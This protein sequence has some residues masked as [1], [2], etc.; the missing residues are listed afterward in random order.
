MVEPGDDFEELGEDEPSGPLLPPDDRLWRHPSELFATGDRPF[1]NQVLA[2]RRQWLA[3]TP[4]RAGAGA[5]GLVGALL[6]AGVVL[7]GVHLTS[8]LTP[9]HHARPTS[10][11]AGLYAAPTE[12]TLP[13][14]SAVGLAGFFDSLNAAIVKVRAVVGARQVM[15]DGVVI[16]QSGDILVAARS[17][18]GALSV[19]V[20]LSDGEELPASLLGSDS[21]TGIAVLKIPEGNLSWLAFSTNH[22]TPVN[23]FLVTAWKRQRLAMQLVSLVKRPARTGLD[24]GPSLLEL[25][26]GSLRLGR[27]PNGAALFDSSGQVIGFVTGHAGHRAVAV[28]GWLAIRVA[29]QLVSNGH[30]SHGWLGIVGETTELSRKVL[31]AVESS[32]PGVLGS[33]HGL[34]RHGVR[35]LSV[36][37]G[38]GA[39]AA[40]LRPGDVIEAVDGQ[41]V[42]SMSDLQAA[43]YL[44]SPSSSVDLEVVRGNRLSDVSVRLQAAA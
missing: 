9:Q 38:S 32:S 21:A 34:Y 12:T 29:S 5:A 35:V 24:G 28:P 42:P 44:M 30:V 27:A 13:S 26:P 10:V 39:A 1:S 7:V 22:A 17:I 16:S 15:S 11:S 6:A 25:C 31:S 20:M 33:G 3:A 23:S 40:G 19:S 4:S 36:T 41:P 18:A 37:S 43:L 8:W 14:V 2:A